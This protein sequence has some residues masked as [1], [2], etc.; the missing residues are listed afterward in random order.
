[1]EFSFSLNSV[2]EI[3]VIKMA[4]TR[5]LPQHQQGTRGRQ[6]LKT[7]H[8]SCFSDLSASLNSLYS[9]KVL[10]HLGNLQCAIESVIYCYPFEFTLNAQN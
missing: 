10:L 7:E 8:N 1:M 5:V 6:D 3:F 9:M 2:T 4:R